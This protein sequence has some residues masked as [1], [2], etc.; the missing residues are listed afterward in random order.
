LKEND[1]GLDP[2]VI[3]DIVGAT[4]TG[5]QDYGDFIWR[6]FVLQKWTSKKNASSPGIARPSGRDS[7]QT[8]PASVAS[9]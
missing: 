1:F 7:L 4:R 9:S 5:K 3:A 8:V 2:A 6:L